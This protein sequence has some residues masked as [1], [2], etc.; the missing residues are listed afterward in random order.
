M[1]TY[2]TP[3]PITVTIELA[4]G[5]VHIVATDRT[6][7]VVTITPH[8]PTSSV[9]MQAAKRI[10]ATHTPGRLRIEQAM[11]WYNH[12]GRAKNG[13][14]TVTIELPAG[15]R[16]RG[17]T[18]MG[19]FRSEGRLGSCDLTS[20]YGDIQLGEITETL[21]AKG[22]SGSIMVG[23]AHADVDAKTTTGSIRVAEVMRGTVVLTTSAGEIEVG[24]RE[25]SAANID[26]RTRLGRVRNTLSSVGSP[27]QYADT[28]KV[29]ARTILDD[30]IVRRS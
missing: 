19:T 29:R 24:V 8:D 4:V 15:S 30:I 13:I 25:G 21:R 7:T 23:R 1:P 27:T 22:T 10:S 5:D 16:V 3:E 11:R 17:T 12:F 18:A 26:V 14:V 6:D 28:V 20:E 9:D 2:S